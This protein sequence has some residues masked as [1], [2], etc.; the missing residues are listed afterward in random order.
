MA[1]SLAAGGGAGVNIVGRY[2]FTTILGTTAMVLA[3]L[4]SLGGFIELVGQLDDIGVGGY[5]LVNAIGWVLMKLPAV[6]FQLLPIGVLLGS[7]LG[8][9][10][11]A[12]RSELIVLRAA[13]MSPTGI[14]RAVLV[15]GL[16][17]AVVGGLL[18]EFVAPPLERFARQYRAMVKFGQG[19]A[20]TGESTWIRE[21]NMLLNVQPPTDDQP[22]GGVYVF[23]LASADALAA[24]GRA[25]VLRQA[26]G[27]QW[28]LDNY[29]ESVFTPTSV[30]TS[31]A[32]QSLAISNLNPDLLGLTLVR[33][34]SMTGKALWRYIQYLKRNGLATRDYEVA[35]WSRF[36]AMVAVPFMCMLAVPFVLG[37]LRGTGTGARMVVGIGIGLAWFLLSRTLADGGAVWG[38]NAVLVAWLPTLLLA[39]ATLWMLRRTR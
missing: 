1:A 9:G 3:V 18:G 5:G 13:G 33:T 39:V 25:E 24:V 26:A 7:L 8:L 22:A 15:T 16:V 27:N 6:L 17:F 20:G 31:S 29:V 32:G 14:A 28:L 34:D 11:L 30:E 37:P 23:R 4:L 21:G 10:M 38:L 19:G 12:S 2:L 35:F 36:A